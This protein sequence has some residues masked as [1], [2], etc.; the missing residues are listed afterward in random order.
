MVFII[1]QKLKQCCK[2]NGHVSNFEEV[3]FG[4]PQRFCLGPLLFLILIN[5]LPLSLKSSKV[6]MYAD[7]TSISFSSKSI[8]T[9]T[10]AVNENKLSFNVT[11]TQSLLIG[12]RYKVKALEQPNSRYP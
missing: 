9:I 3:K 8:C 11:K 2:V 1:P 7:D 5:D 10:N 6:N 4:V 12:S